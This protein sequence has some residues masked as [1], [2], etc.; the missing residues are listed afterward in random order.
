MAYFL[1]KTD[2]E[3]Y[4][5]DSLELEKKTVWDGIRNAQALQA[6]RQ[7]K[8]G[9]T[10]MIYHSGGQSAVVGVAKVISEA[11]PDP[12][13]SK[14]W[15]IDIEFAHKFESPVTLAEIKTSGLFNDWSLVR[16]SRLSTMSVPESFIDWLSQRGALK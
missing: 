14:S 6:I 12:N 1:A 2:P 13:D 5:I 10:V 4:S 11:R 15:V 7:M 16:Q 3:T 8:P 9:D